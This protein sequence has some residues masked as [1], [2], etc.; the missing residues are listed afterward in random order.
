MSSTKRN[1][2]ID[3]TQGVIWKQLLKFAVP[4]FLASLIQ[5]LYSTVDLLCAGN[6]IGKQATAAVGASSLVITCLVNFFTGVIA[7]VYPLAW[8]STSVC[9]LVYWKKVN[10]NSVSGA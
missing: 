3:L 2:Q 1:T 8:F 10:K 5:Q 6:F 7:A 9:L 4:L